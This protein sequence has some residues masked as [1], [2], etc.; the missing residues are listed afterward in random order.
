MEIKRY[1]VLFSKGL[2]KKRKVFSDGTLIVKHLPTSITMV[3]LDNDGK[4]VKRQNNKTVGDH[5]PGDEFQF[6]MNI[7]QVESLLEVS[8]AA[9]NTIGDVLEGQRQSAPSAS[10]SDLTA[11]SQMAGTANLQQ[12][13]KPPTSIFKH[14]KDV[15]NMGN[16]HL[17]VR[18]HQ[19]QARI[20]ANDGNDIDKN[21]D[22]D[23][24]DADED[25]LP[26]KKQFSHVVGRPKPNMLPTGQDG[27]LKTC[28]KTRPRLDTQLQRS[29]KAHQV[30]AA[31][32]LLNA[33]ASN[34][35]MVRGAILADEVCISPVVKYL[36]SY[37]CVAGLQ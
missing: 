31:Q 2:E 29:M 33:L 20:A 22:I 15:A 7:V 12:K 1:A 4:E 23:V 16:R 34:E 17:V 27:L 32:F 25:E 30:E 26:H 21:D 9:P 24:N 36:L 35:D 19:Q 8:T 14:H 5:E 11:G 28:A 6:G 37:V 13:R 3:L 18:T 10:S